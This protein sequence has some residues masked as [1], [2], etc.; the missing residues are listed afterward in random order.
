[1]SLYPEDGQP[2][3]AI[4]VGQELDFH[5]CVPVRQI[6]FK[7][8]TAL[9]HLPHPKQSR[10]ICGEFNVPLKNLDTMQQSIQFSLVRTTKWV[11]PSFRT[12]G[13]AIM[14]DQRKPQSLR[15]K[16]VTIVTD[17]SPQTRTASHWK[18]AGGE[19]VG[20]SALVHESNKN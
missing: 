15:E 3:L 2:G 19:T 7:Y 17:P 18:T 12:D 14:V 1:M 11:L 16:M 13:T 8:V 20:I 6:V 10:T 5:Q 4:I 9:N